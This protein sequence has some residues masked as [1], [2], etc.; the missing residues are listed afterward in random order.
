MEIHDLFLNQL[1]RVMQ[2]V[3]VQQAV[4]TDYDVSYYM[5]HTMD[6]LDNRVDTVVFD[7]SFHPKSSVQHH[8]SWVLQLMVLQQ[9]DYLFD[10][11]PLSHYPDQVDVL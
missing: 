3:M 2:R 5:V 9:P 11:L 8:L 6:N 1:C 4:S 10:R 7:H